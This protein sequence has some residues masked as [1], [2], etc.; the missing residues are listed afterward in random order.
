VGEAIGAAAEAWEGEEAEFEG[1]IRGW[2]AE[3]VGKGVF[4]GK[5]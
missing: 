1:A 2:F 3:W 4:E 5:R